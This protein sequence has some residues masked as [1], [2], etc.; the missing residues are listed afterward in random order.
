MNDFDAAKMQTISKEIT[1]TNLE[2]ATGN[3]NYNTVTLNY[4]GTDYKFA[5]NTSDNPID[6]FG[7]LTQEANDLDIEIQ[8]AMY[9]FVQH[10]L[11]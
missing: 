3:R 1:L 9:K 11:D 5:F 4:K 2:L 7:G 10:E 6:F 8:T